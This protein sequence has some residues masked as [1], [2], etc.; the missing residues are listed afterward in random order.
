MHKVKKNE[1]ASQRPWLK[2]Y[3]AGVPENISYERL[4]MPEILERS[5]REHPDA[6]ILRYQNG[7]IYEEPEKK[8]AKA[9]DSADRIADMIKQRI[10]DK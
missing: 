7:D 4:C 5:A 10:L 2:S 9:D 8:P 6:K 3:T 1:G